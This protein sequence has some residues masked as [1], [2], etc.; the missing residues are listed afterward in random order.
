M[1]NVFHPFLVDGTNETAWYEETGLHA[2]G[3][4]ITEELC[5]G[6]V[7]RKEGARY[8]R[9]KDKIYDARLFGMKGD[10]IAMNDEAFVKMNNTCRQLGGAKFHL[11]KGK[12]LFNNMIG[13]NSRS[14]YQ[15]SNRFELIGDGPDNTMIKFVH[16]TKNGLTLGDRTSDWE[17]DGQN[18]DLLFT[19]SAAKK[20]DSYIDLKDKTWSG[21]FSVGKVVAIVNGAHYYDQQFCELN[22]ITRVEADQGRL[23][24]EYPLAREY[25]PGMA[26]TWGSITAAFI[27]PPVGSAVTVKVDGNFPG[28][29]QKYVSVGENIYRIATRF[30][31]AATL[32]NIG[33]GNEQAGTE[34]LP[35]KVCYSRIITIANCTQGFRMS[36]VQMECPDNAKIVRHLRVNACYDIVFKNCV[37]NISTNNDFK[38]INAALHFIDMGTKVDFL[39]CVLDGGR[40]TVANQNSRSSGRVL[41]QNCVFRNADI[42]YSEYSYETSWIHC[43]FYNIKSVVLGNSTYSSL[44]ESCEFHTDLAVRPRFF[45]DGEI[46]NISNIQKGRC[47]VRDCMVKL[48]NEREIQWLVYINMR[49]RGGYIEYSNCVFEGDYLK[50]AFSPNN[51]KANRETDSFY[52]FKNN[53]IR[54]IPYKP[55]G[56]LELRPRTDHADFELANN[57]F[58]LT[59]D[60]STIDHNTFRILYLTPDPNGSRLVVRDNSFYGFDQNNLT[61]DVRGLRKESVTIL[62][63]SFNGKG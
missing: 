29:R 24:L 14:N 22:R 36:N 33:K 42:D 37:I 47:I 17:M 10:G 61:I 19:Y 4:K 6:I 28:E 38:T 1:A 31:A 45:Y 43:K 56:L 23:F 27:Q 11:P 46:Q 12:Y 7:F 41:Y 62:D 60:K 57:K 51:D 40:V 21:H 30:P 32:I 18:E 59:G 20:G 25:A 3:A 39:D 48:T 53:I 2:T 16:P 34:I 13:G 26:Q 58:Y 44:L 55:Y 35:Q 54:T 5:D 15:I 52:S 9:L 49:N 8:Y 63:N 50:L